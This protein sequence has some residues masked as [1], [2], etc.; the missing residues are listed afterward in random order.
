[1]LLKPLSSSLVAL[2]VAAGCASP[3]LSS[4]RD[5]RSLEGGHW[6]HLTKGSEMGQATYVGPRDAFVGYDHASGNG[7]SV[8]VQSPDESRPKTT[9]LPGTPPLS[10]GDRVRI[11]LPPK[12]FFKGVFDSSDTALAG[13]YE[14]GFDGQLKL[15]YIK[16]VAVAGVPVSEAEVMINQA[17]EAGGYFKP[18]MAR[19]NLSIQEWAP[20]QVSVA[21]AVFTP[22]TVSLSPRDASLS[23]DQLKLRGGSASLNR[24]LSTA[25]Q[26]AG[27]V[28]PDADIQRVELIRHGVVHTYDLSG[29][30]AGHQVQDVALIQGDQ[31]RV[32]SLGVPDARIIRPSAITPPGIRVFISNLTVPAFHNASS[33]V[34]LHSTSLPYGAQLHTAVVSGNCAGGAALTNSDRY[35]VLVTTD[36]V[37]RRPITVERRIEQVLSN[38]GSRSINPYLMP[39]DSVVCY[40]SE[41][42]NIRDIGR[43]ISD[44]LAPIGVFFR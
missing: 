6:M 41:I 10:P 25:L 44:V 24:L 23:G 43:A 32:T 15:P 8:D 11:D 36:P 20:I 35:A 13:I 18:G 14:V 38:P 9:G 4:S 3:D 21:G 31:I 28:R 39:N 29:T 40:D 2:A 12:A 19:L 1:M 42:S 34:E 33:A 5:E 22:G 37:T 30:V 16:P 17:L 27:G 26:S 7:S